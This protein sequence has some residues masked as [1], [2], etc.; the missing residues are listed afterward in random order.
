MRKTFYVLLGMLALTCA[1]ALSGPE[2]V[3]D[4][5]ILPLESDYLGDMILHKWPDSKRPLRVFVSPPNER[6]FDAREADTIMRAVG[7]WLNAQCTLSV[8]PESDYMKADIVFNRVASYDELPQYGS[9]GYTY[10][11]YDPKNRK[12]VMRTRTLL[13]CPN[14]NYGDLSE[15]ER[16]A[17]YTLAMHEAGHAFGLDGHSSEPEDIMFAKAT[18]ANPSRRDLATIIHVYPKVS[19]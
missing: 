4:P 14:P 2:R 11:D 13:Y 7:Q 15:T 10:Y 5:K 12:Q 3:I 8:V 16:E 18:A 1:P 6:G 19:K 9:A 17:F